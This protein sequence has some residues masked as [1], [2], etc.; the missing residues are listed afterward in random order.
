MKHYETQEK[1]HESLL[2]KLR[3]LHI[4]KH[5]LSPGWWFQVSTPLKNMSV[6]MMTFP[7]YGKIK[8]WPKAPTSST[9]L[10]PLFWWGQ[11][12]NRSTPQAKW[13]CQ[14]TYPQ[15]SHE[16]LTPF[17]AGRAWSFDGVVWIKS[18]VWNILIWLICEW[19]MIWWFGISFMDQTGLHVLCGF[20]SWIM[21]CLIIFCQF[22]GCSGQ[23]FQIWLVKQWIP[24]QVFQEP[25]GFCSSLDPIWTLTFGHFLTEFRSMVTSSASFFGWS[26][27]Q[28]Y[29]QEHPRV[30]INRWS[31][32]TPS[33]VLSPMANSRPLSVSSKLCLA[34]MI[35]HGALINW[36]LIA[37]LA[38]LHE[39]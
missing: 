21:T 16:A 2:L 19:T 13:W 26:S 8:K 32:K 4:I 33:Y 31:R 30:P 20:D 18:I 29:S 15:R 5:D 6:G 34:N 17:P 27:A 25:H 37:K 38:K 14:A 3:T 11:P 28:R 7:I 39:N 10:T 12:V 24:R 22:C 1:K 23:T 36:F 35:H 9:M